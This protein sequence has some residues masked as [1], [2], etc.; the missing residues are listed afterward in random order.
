MKCNAECDI[1]KTKNIYAE[2]DDENG[3]GTLSE[4]A[5][6]ILSKTGWSVGYY[7]VPLE[8]DGVTEKVRSLTS[9]GKTGAYKLLTTLCDLFKVY[10]VFDSDMHT[11]SFY[12]LENREYHREFLVGGAS[13]DAAEVTGSGAPIG[14][15]MVGIMVVG[16]DSRTSFVR[17]GDIVPSA[18]GVTALTVENDSSSIITRMYVEGQYLDDGYVGIDDVNPTGLTYIM[19]FDYYREIG[20]FTETHEA[21]LEAYEN[22]MAAV[23]SSIRTYQQQI[24]TLSNEVNTLWGQWNLIEYVIQ[25]QA[26]TR[27][28]LGGDAKEEQAPI[29]EGDKLIVCGKDGDEFLYREVDVPAGGMVWNATDEY[30]V[31]LIHPTGSDDYYRAAGQVGAKEVG[32]EAKQS[33]IEE[34]DRKIAIVQRVIDD[35]ERQGIPVPQ[36]RLDELA[37]YQTEKAGL[38]AQIDEIYDGN[39][40]TEEGSVATV[41]LRELTYEAMQKFAQLDEAKSGV[42]A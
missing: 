13:K 4:L 25:N 14:V 32:I 20:L 7:D 10:P 31:K 26:V 3:I 29:T 36:A 27:H 8:K 39:D 38:L 19:N 18:Y 37:R 21:A 11:V 40:G 33:A 24:M 30:A 42:T 22:D 6:K 23:V 9:S 5:S 34:L 16:Y 1:L 15:G 28:I 12:G 2:F 35:L 17:E 41:G